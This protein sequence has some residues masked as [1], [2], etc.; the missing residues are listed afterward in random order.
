M[1]AVAATTFAAATS[2]T[3]AT[4]APFAGVSRLAAGLCTS[5]FTIAPCWDPLFGQLIADVPPIFGAQARVVDIPQ[6]HGFTG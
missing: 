6:R 4:A 1:T 5:A 3:F 2:T